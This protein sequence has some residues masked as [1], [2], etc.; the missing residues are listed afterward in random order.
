M[1]AT[2]D[3]SFPGIGEMLNADF[4]VAD[5]LGRAEKVKT[6]AEAAAPFD[7]NSKDGGHYK[8]SFTA[9]AAAHGGAKKDRAVG[10]VTNTDEAAFFIEFGNVNIAKHR[11]LGKSLDAAR[12]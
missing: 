12:D 5:M 8:D 11:V 3:A 7:P 10:T 2:F 4:M 1:G 6:A 9:S